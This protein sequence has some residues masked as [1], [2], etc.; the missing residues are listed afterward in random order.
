MRSNQYVGRK[1]LIQ[2]AILCRCGIDTKGI[3]FKLFYS[4]I[5]ICHILRLWSNA[6]PC[7][8]YHT[9]HTEQLMGAF[10]WIC[11]NRYPAPLRK[12][13]T[14]TRTQTSQ[15]PRSKQLLSKY[16]SAPLKDGLKT[17]SKVVCNNFLFVCC[18]SFMLWRRVVL[19][20]MYYRVNNW[21]LTRVPPGWHHKCFVF[22]PHAN[23]CRL[24]ICV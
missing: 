2:R 6:I 24:T 17:T 4:N 16:Q 13:S 1:Q 9:N 3:F 5:T 11:R 15:H 21:L 22:L 7:F 20:R 10:L 8:K 19:C 14:G 18:V 12:R 23:G